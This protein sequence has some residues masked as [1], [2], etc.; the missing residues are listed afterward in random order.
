MENILD[1]NDLLNRLG[2]EDLIKEIVP[3][4]LS[5]DLDYIDVLR[6]AVDNKD[7]GEVQ[8]NAHSLKGAS[9]SIGAIPLS[10][11]AKKLESMA[12]ELSLDEAEDALLEIKQEYDKLIDLLKQP[13]WADIAQE[14]AKNS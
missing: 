1:W 9:A 11:A 13:N 8:L 3:E 2:D 6:K 12:R 7:T 14:S 5:A 4:F 10:N